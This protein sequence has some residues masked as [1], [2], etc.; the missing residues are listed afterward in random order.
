MLQAKLWQLPVL[1]LPWPFDCRPEEDVAVVEARLFCSVAD[2]GCN[3]VCREAQRCE[4]HHTRPVL[5][6][7]WAA[8]YSGP[9]VPTLYRSSVSGSPSDKETA[10]RIESAPVQGAGNFKDWRCPTFH[11]T[12]GKCCEGRYVL[13]SFSEHCAACNASER[14]AIVKLSISAVEA[15][16][17]HKLSCR[18]AAVA[19]RVTK[20]ESLSQVSAAE[21]C[22]K[23]CLRKVGLSTGTGLDV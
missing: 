8:S 7:Q 4:S 14:L 1:E 13:A 21:G 2:R 12:S 11:T 3:L 23:L 20:L 15:C 9:A 22:D 5:Q 16:A 6:F 10:P 19:R 17:Q 18:F